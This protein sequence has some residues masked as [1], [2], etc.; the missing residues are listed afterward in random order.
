MSPEEFKTYYK[1]PPKLEI[2][3]LYIATQLL[4]NPACNQNYPTPC[5]N[6][7]QTRTLITKYI[8]DNSE[9]H[10]RIVQ[11]PMDP[12]LPQQPQYSSPSANI[13]HNPSKFS[14]QTIINHKLME[15]KDK[16]KITK[17]YNTYL[18][19]WRLNNHNMYNKWM[20]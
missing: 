2:S 15:T 1:N 16:Y 11:R 12:A 18:C 5:H 17:N 6:H 19:Q 8:S 14:I 13:I 20:P 9:L 4:C 7:I 10:P 3:T